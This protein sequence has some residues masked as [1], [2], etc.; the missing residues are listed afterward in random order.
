MGQPDS[1][2][3]EELVLRPPL[4]SCMRVMNWKTAPDDSQLY[5]KVGMLLIELTG[6]WPSYTSRHLAKLSLCTRSS[7]S[8]WLVWQI[9]S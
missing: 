5:F 9:T 2:T 3:W 6:L 7:F 8:A 4:G 1:A